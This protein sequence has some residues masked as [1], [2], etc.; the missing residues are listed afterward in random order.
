M[1]TYYLYYLYS[2]GGWAVHTTRGS[3]QAMLFCPL[4]VSYAH[5]LH[6]IAMWHKVGGRGFVP[7]ERIILKSI[8]ELKRGASGQFNDDYFRDQLSPADARLEMA[9]PLAR[10][11]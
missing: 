6:G 11:R 8:A 5:E 7:D 3:E 1:G 9:D 10:A 2:L 4:S